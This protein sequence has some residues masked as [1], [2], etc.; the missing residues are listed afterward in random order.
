MKLSVL[1]LRL[2]LALA[3]FCFTPGWGFA[4]PRPV[5]VVVP[6]SDG[7]V[8]NTADVVANLEVRAESLGPG[9]CGIQFSKIGVTI[10]FVAPPLT[11]SPWTVLTGS[12]GKNRFELHD[13][14]KCDTGILGQV[15]Y[16]SDSGVRLNRKKNI[17]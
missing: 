2:S 4:A 7:M 5:Q 17:H 8:V 3:T 9:G 12:V 1:R 15:R 6:F 14:V 10:G 11:Y 13:S 16:F